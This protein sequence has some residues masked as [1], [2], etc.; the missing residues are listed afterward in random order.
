MRMH[1]SEHRDRHTPIL[2]ENDRSLHE[3][4]EVMQDIASIGARAL[5]ARSCRALTARSCRA[6]DDKGI[7]KEARLKLAGAQRA[8]AE[9][10]LC[11]VLSIQ[12]SYMT[13]SCEL[14]G[15]AVPS[16]HPLRA[17]HAQQTLSLER[18]KQWIVIASDEAVQKMYDKSCQEIS[19][20]DKAFADRVGGFGV[21]VEKLKTLIDVIGTVHKK[22]MSLLKG[23]PDQDIENETPVRITAPGKWFGRSGVIEERADGTNFDYSVW[24]H[25]EDG[26]EDAGEYVMFSRNEVEPIEDVPS[27]MPTM[28]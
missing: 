19:G 5:A 25:D 9:A 10:Y 26:G 27:T 16:R 23:R 1:H 2:A 8:I 3:Y 6:L 22:L 14:N 7:S 20:A 17:S 15:E 18:A 12:E 21:L 11:Q 28:Q 13:A 4:M 24:V